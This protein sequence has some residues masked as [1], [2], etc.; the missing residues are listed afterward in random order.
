[1]NIKNKVAIVTGG[2]SGLGEATAR[3][4]VANGGKVLIMDLNMERGKA[5]VEEL[6]KDKVIFDKTDVTSESSE[7]YLNYIR[8]FQKHREPIY[9][10]M[11]K[12]SSVRRLW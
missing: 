12:V 11:M 3:N 9:F 7:Y 2:A 4:I 5:I 1:M 8:Y 10:V 6:G